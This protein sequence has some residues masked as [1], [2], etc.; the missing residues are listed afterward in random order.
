MELGK[1]LCVS[2]GNRYQQLMAG[3]A[4]E[5][6]KEYNTLLYKLNQS[7]RLKKDNAVFETTI[8]SVNQKGKLITRDTM[9]REFDWGEVEFVN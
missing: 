6:L 1:E 8:I 5:Q 3:N 2:L 4:N 9:D 7:V